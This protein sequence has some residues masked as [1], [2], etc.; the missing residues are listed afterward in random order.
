MRRRRASSPVTR[1]PARSR[2]PDISGESRAQVIELDRRDLVFFFQAE[3]G[4]RD[5]AV[6]G[7]QTCALPICA[8]WQARVAWP[9]QNNSQGEHMVR[10][11]SE[12]DLFKTNKASQ[13]QTR[14]D[15][16]DDAKRH[17]HDHEKPA[18]A[19][20][21]NGSGIA[22]SFFQFVTDFAARRLECRK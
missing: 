6:T 20:A 18:R 21:S 2:S 12:R 1:A 8:L 5:V 10:P 16:N 22:S 4:I 17:F 13:Q 11:K 14:A 9:A 7:V 19:N 3:D 15:E